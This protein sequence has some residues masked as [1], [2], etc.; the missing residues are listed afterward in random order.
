MY[1]IERNNDQCDSVKHTKSEI[2]IRKGLDN[3][4]SQYYW[5]GAAQCR[6][7]QSE[8]RPCRLGRCLEIAVNGSQERPTLFT[9]KAEKSAD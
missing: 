3:V 5:L 2:K 4:V 6:W 9:P 8:T 7:I 1:G